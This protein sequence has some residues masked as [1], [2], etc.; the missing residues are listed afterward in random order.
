MDGGICSPYWRDDFLAVGDPK[1]PVT[2]DRFRE[3]EY[4]HS[5]PMIRGTFQVSLSQTAHDFR[6]LSPTGISTI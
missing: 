2:D 4:K 5:R 3:A 1:A 6:H